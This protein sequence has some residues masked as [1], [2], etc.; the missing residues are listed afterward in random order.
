M[1]SEAKKGNMSAQHNM[2]LWNETVVED[3]DE[4]LQWY[5]RAAD[6]GHEGAQNAM[7]ELHSKISAGK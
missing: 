2:G 1:E 6:S 7:E 5:R 4:A 3:Y